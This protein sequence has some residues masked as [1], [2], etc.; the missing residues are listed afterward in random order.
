[1]G[2]ELKTSPMFLSWISEKIA[3]FYMKYKR[4]GTGMGTGMIGSILDMLSAEYLGLDFL[5]EG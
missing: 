5:I 2:A 1:M 3:M 4:V